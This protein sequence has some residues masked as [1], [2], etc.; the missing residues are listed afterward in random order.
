MFYVSASVPKICALNCLQERVK[1]Q[2]NILHRF[3]LSLNLSWISVNHRQSINAMDCYL[4]VASGQCVLCDKFCGTFSPCGRS[5]YSWRTY[6]CQPQQ[7]LLVSLVGADA[8]LTSCNK[9]S[10]DSSRCGVLTKLIK[11]VVVDSNRLSTLSL[12]GELYSI[13]TVR[14]LLCTVMFWSISLHLTLFCVLHTRLDATLRHRHWMPT[15]LL[16]SRLQMAV[17]VPALSG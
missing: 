3:F 9:F 1:F 6:C 7:I 11:S 17:S 12:L 13:C 5:N 4:L 16:I 10:S 2:S 8:S 15:Y 14:L